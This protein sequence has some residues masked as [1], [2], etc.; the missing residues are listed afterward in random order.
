MEN[1]KDIHITLKQFLISIII[2]I[3]IATTYTQIRNINNIQEA[4]IAEIETEDLQEANLHVEPVTEID[5]QQGNTL[6]ERNTAEGQVLSRSA[7]TM[8]RTNLEEQTNVENAETT[9]ITESQAY[10]TAQEIAISKDMDLTVRT[11]LSKED[12]KNLIANVK[13]DKSKFFYENSDTIYDLCEEY[14]LNE[15]FFCGLI[16][17]ESGWNIV[18]SHRNTHNYI[19]L[20]SNGKLI[21]YGSVEEGLRVAAQKL[22]NNYLSEGGKFYYGKTL[23]AVKTKF[24]PSDSKWINLVYERMEEIVESKW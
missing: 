1:I 20:M 23:S 14:Q 19:S 13:Q 4:K 5:E 24:C 15:I 10:K 7:T 9:E 8:R 6:I 18:Q 22:H 16:S 21:S 2:M 17:A 11:G 12:F 3:A